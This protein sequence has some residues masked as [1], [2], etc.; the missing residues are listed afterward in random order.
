MPK[1]TIEGKNATNHRGI[2][3]LVD[4]V[5][6]TTG[7]SFHIVEKRKRVPKRGLLGRLK[8]SE[9]E[10][11]FETYVL[12]GN[13]HQEVEHAKGCADTIVSFL[14]GLLEGYTIGSQQCQ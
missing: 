11:Y 6:K 7:R 2:T 5:N 14:K 10:S 8:H 13:A 9:Y 12:Q 4:S 1:D 3:V